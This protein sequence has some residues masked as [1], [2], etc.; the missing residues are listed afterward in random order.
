MYEKYFMNLLKKKTR[1]NNKSMNKKKD[2]TNSKSRSKNEMKNYNSQT[3]IY[4]FIKEIK[5]VN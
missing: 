5:K 4:E 1:S 3:E 2:M